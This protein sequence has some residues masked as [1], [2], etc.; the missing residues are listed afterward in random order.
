MVTLGEAARQLGISKPTLSKAIS[1]GQLSATRREDGSFAIDPSELVRWWDGV[2]HRFQPQPVIDLQPATHSAGTETADTDGVAD[3]KR[4]QASNGDPEVSARFAALEAELRGLRELVQ[5]V[6][7]SRDTA[8]ETAD[9]WRAQAERL[10]LALPKPAARDGLAWEVATTA[11]HLE[12]RVV[13]A[14]RQELAAS[15]D[16][17]RS[18]WPWRRRAG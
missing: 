9:H 18:W 14:N 1:K 6:R 16:S 3:R 7:A 10:T 12:P 15:T 8:R 11:D 2:K 4:E 17:L 5:E 13:D